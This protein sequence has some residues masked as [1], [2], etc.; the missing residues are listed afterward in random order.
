MTDMIDTEFRKLRTSQCK[1]KPQVNLKE[2]IVRMTKPI[3]DYT[4]DELSAKIEAIKAERERTANALKKYEEELERRKQEVPLGVPCD[5][6][7]CVNFNGTMCNFNDKHSVEETEYNMFNT[8]ES[9]KKHREMLLAWRK[10]LVANSKGEPIDIKVLLPLLKKGWV[11]MDKDEDWYWYSDKPTPTGCI[12]NC[13][14][15][16]NNR[17]GGFNIKPAEN[18]GTSLMGCG[19]CTY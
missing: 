6:N 19:L 5:G 15:G 18:W 14:V 9:A 12:W 17:I 10:A 16:C 1:N 7:F 3:E 4:A 2:R 8:L 11:A 13:N